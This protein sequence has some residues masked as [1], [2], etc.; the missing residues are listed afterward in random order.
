MGTHSIAPFTEGIDNGF[1][2]YGTPNF[3][4]T[5]LATTRGHLL[6]GHILDSTDCIWQFA[7]HVVLNSGLDYIS[8]FMVVHMMFI[9]HYL[10]CPLP[11]H[12][13][14]RAPLRVAICYLAT[15]LTVPIAFGHLPPM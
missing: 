6:L 8:S 12:H 13:I 15:Y 9:D 1:Y 7:T 2:S 4:N 3:E 14:L 5:N 10:T 11:D